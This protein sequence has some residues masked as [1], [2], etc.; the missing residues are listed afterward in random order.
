MSIANSLRRLQTL[1]ISDCSQLEKIIQGSEVSN[2]SLQSLREVKVENCNNLRYLFPMSIANSLGGLQTLERC[3]GLEE[4]IKAKKESN[5]CLYSLMEVF[6]RE[7]N[8][9]TS[10][11]SLSHGRILKSLTKL[12]I[13]DCLQLEDTF[14]ISM[15]QGLPLLNEVVLE[16][17]PQFKERD[18]NEI[19]LTLA[20]L[21][22]LAEVSI[23]DCENLKY[24]FPIT[25]AHGGI[26]KLKTISLEKVSKLEQV[27]EGD[28]AN[29]SKDEEKVLHLPQLTDLKLSGLP[30]LMSFSP[31]SYHFVFPSFEDLEAEGC[32]N[33][34]TRF[35]VDSKQSVHAKTQASQSDD[36]TILEESAAAQETT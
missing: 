34:T 35:S 5:I 15:A 30:N 6:V 18:G 29:V 12:E 19:V 22:N 2:I 31:V 20:S 4:I 16:D 26:L 14:P 13:Y 1:Q 3:F 33:I 28:E 24:L 27:F 23:R 9:L 17:L 36:E 21:H 7:C 11:S 32:P 10:L 25:F 8:M